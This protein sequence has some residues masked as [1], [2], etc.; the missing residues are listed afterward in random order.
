MQ[1]VPPKYWYLMTNIHGKYPRGLDNVDL[2]TIIQVIMRILSII[3]LAYSV[4]IQQPILRN[5]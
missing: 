1:Q 3:I 4:N 2:Y 5:S